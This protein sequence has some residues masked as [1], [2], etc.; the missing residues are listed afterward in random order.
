MTFVPGRV[1][2]S[3]GQKSRRRAVVEARVVHHGRDVDN[4]AEYNNLGQTTKG[5]AAAAMERVSG[6]A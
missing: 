2:G 6:A 3:P 1:V 4:G 5:A